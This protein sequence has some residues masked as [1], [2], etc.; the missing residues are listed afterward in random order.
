MRYPREFE[1]R[2]IMLKAHTDTGSHL[3]NSKNY[4]KDSRKLDINGIKW[5]MM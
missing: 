3:K 1:A 2:E 4:L 5:Q